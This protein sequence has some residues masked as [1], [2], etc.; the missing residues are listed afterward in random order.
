MTDSLLVPAIPDSIIS[1]VDDA[2]LVLE[3]RFF[4]QRKPLGLR[5]LPS[6]DSKHHC[7]FG[8]II[9]IIIIAMN[10]YTVQNQIGQG[11]FGDVYLAVKKDTGAKVSKAAAAPPCACGNVD[12]RE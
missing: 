2:G 4:D 6:A 1:H 3:V 7:L 8:C 11:S 10:R 9:I 5:H 12:L